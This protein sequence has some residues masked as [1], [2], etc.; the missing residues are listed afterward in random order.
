L[1]AVRA[2]TFTFS[3]VRSESVLDLPLHN[4]FS[5]CW[6]QSIRARQ[7]ESLTSGS[8]VDTATVEVKRARIVFG[9]RAESTSTTD[10]Y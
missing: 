6:R 3:R 4:N 9:T 5:S 8:L 7:G 10:L 2:G 1:P